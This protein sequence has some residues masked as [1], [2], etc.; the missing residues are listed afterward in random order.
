MIYCAECHD[1]YWYRFMVS[2][3]QIT[4]K[5]FKACDHHMMYGYAKF[6]TLYDL[7]VGCSC[8]TT[9][10]CK[11]PPGF[12]QFRFL[13]LWVSICVIGLSQHHNTFL[14]LRQ[15]ISCCY[16]TTLLLLTTMNWLASAAGG[17]CECEH[18]CTKSHSPF[19]STTVNPWPI[20]L[21]WCLWLS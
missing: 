21:S 17:S 18:C 13:S 4:N 6:C 16:F 19:E 1:H 3:W 10:S 12:Q 2:I 11:V 20:H 9:A 15:C 8:I 7:A 14:A 5:S